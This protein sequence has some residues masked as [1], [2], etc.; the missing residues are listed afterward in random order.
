[1]KLSKK[2][3]KKLKEQ[4]LDDILR[5]FRYYAA[6]LKGKNYTTLEKDKDDKQ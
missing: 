4:L 2:Q 6:C 3:Y 1:M 5:T